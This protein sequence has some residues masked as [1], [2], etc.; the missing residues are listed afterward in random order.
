MMEMKNLRICNL[1]L[2]ESGKL[3][4][5]MNDDKRYFPSWLTEEQI[6][7][8]LMNSKIKF[9]KSYGFDGHKMFSSIG[10]DRRGTW[11]LIDNDY[12]NE[13]Q[14]GSSDIQE[15]ILIV[16]KK[17]PGVVIGHPVNDFPVVVAYDF[18]DDVAAVAYCD[19]ENIDK[20]M[21]MM[22]VDALYNYNRTS[23][24][25]VVAYIS[26]CAGSSLAYD[27]YPNEAKY[28]DVWKD[29]IEENDGEYHVNLK[30][31]IYKQL[32]N[33]KVAKIFFS[34]VDTIKDD[35]FYSLYATKKLEKTECGTNYS[36]AFIKVKK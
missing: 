18:K 11:F 2:V 19:M 3:Y 35:Y 17:T 33:R 8:G 30:G 23:E 14:F 29:Y 9:G 34:S 26:A 16:D 4:G 13:H 28:S 5:N 12:V 22:V 1:Q 6:K 32:Q 7:K 31:A 24:E 36:G 21:P 25:N 10:K 15:D 27:E 20:K